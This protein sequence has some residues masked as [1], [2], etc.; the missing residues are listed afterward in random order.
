M[1]HSHDRPDTSASAADSP[2]RHDVIVIGA[3]WAGLSAAV[4][5]VDA[6]LKPLILEAAPQPGGR[7]R[8]VT[9]V[10]DGKRCHLDN[11]QHLLVGAYRET[12]ALIERVGGSQPAAIARWPM[13]LASVDGLEMT[14][15]AAPPPLDLAGALLLARGLSLTE[16]WALVRQLGRLRLRGWRVPGG[17]TVAQWLSTGRQPDSL[18]RRFWEPLCLATLNTSLAAACARTFANV[19]RDTLGRDAAACEFVLPTNA[20]DDVLP[21]PASRWLLSHGASVRLRTPVRAIRPGPHGHWRIDTEGMAGPQSTAGGL[22][23]RQ[24]VLA[25]PPAN[26]S[27]MLAAGDCPH[28][29]GRLRGFE[30]EPIATIYL[31]W[32]ADAA[33]ALPRWIMLEERPRDRALG[34][35]LFDR[36]SQHA[37]RIA[38]VVVSAHGRT[39]LADGLCGDELARQ[40]ARQVADQLGVPAPC[41]ARAI[42]DKRATF[43]C[44]PGRPL[45]DVDALQPG[46]PGLW[47]AGDHCWPDYPATLEAAVRSG[48]LAAQRCLQASVRDAGAP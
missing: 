33:P 3:G 10:L 47:L 21:V 48:R 12:L 11:G 8:A 44:T 39:L 7:A 25:L 18:I 35:W 42:I 29:A 14:P 40:V 30:S 16:R 13:R 27:R 22:C 38:A 24:V 31:A 37:L 5:L 17:S 20:L 43:R 6:G 41:D 2:E 4:G 28:D 9:L 34:Q 26:A 36:G 23:A 19:L 46:L 32:P 1:P 45:L 15:V